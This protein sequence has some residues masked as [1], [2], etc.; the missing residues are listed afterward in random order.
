MIDVPHQ[1]TFVSD[2]VMSHPHWL[3][4]VPPTGVPAR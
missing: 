3:T 1:D 2:S 4:T